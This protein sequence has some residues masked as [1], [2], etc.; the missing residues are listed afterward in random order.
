M[1][2]KCRKINPAYCRSCRFSGGCPEEEH[3]KTYSKASGEAKPENVYYDGAR[4]DY[5]EKGK[6][7]KKH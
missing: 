6:K 1:G 7:H 4:C 5:Y 3:C 2:N